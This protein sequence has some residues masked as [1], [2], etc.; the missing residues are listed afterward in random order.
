MVIDYLM[1]SEHRKF[2]KDFAMTLLFG[3]VTI[4]R[5]KNVKFCGGSGLDKVGSFSLG[6]RYI[7]AS[8]MAHFGIL[9][10][11]EQLDYL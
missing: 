9:F 5:K 10:Q 3:K 6:F 1:I 8:I 2:Y 7:L 4:K 11:W